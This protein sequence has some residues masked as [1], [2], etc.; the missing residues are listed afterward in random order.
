M[1]HWDKKRELQE[2]NIYLNNYK[3]MKT[4]IV[5]TQYIQN[6]WGY[7][8]EAEERQ[9]FINW[10]KECVS[11]S[12][13]YENGQAYYLFKNNWGNWSTWETIT[14]EEEISVEEIENYVYAGWLSAETVRKKLGL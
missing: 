5:R 13:L 1:F 6:E 8:W 2:Q 14:R 4:I 10:D 12:E 9:T 3:I 7:E 11:Y